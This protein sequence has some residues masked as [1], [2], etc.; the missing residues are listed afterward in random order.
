A[1]GGQKYRTPATGPQPVGVPNPGE[2]LPE[3]SDGA[4]PA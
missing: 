3:S 1:N 2:P 4:T